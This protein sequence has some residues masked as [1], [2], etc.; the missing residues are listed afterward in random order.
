MSKQLNIS[1][2][3]DLCYTVISSSITLTSE[4]YGTIVCRPNTSEVINITLPTL[5]YNNIGWT[6]R[7]SNP[8]Q[9][10]G[11][12]SSGAIV[13][14][15][16]NYQLLTNTVITV[17]WD[18]NRFII[19]D[20][21]DLY[22]SLGNQSSGYNHIETI[23]ESTTYVPT[24]TGWYKVTCIGAGGGGGAGGGQLEGSGGLGGSIGGTTSFSNAL[25]ALGGGGGG[26]GAC[27]SGGAGGG[28]GSIT[29]DYIYLT[30]GQPVT[31]TIGQGGAGGNT[32]TGGS[33][34][35]G[36]GGGYNDALYG[37]GG[38]G[39]FRHGSGSPAGATS[40]DTYQEYSS[41]KVGGSGG[42]NSTGYGGGG[43]GGATINSIGGTAGEL[44][45]NGSNGTE[46]N[47]GNGGN[48]GNGAVILEYFKVGK[49]NRG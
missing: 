28:A 36:A 45:S 30:A 2:W 8:T 16:T 6:I 3:I 22:T 37:G 20:Y 4:S 23:T 46:S 24:Y 25:S 1:K 12:G 18:G 39:I 13:T 40:G 32:Q 44:G 38:Q 17:Y 15:N 49:T 35:G 5:S 7:I 43:G 42:S 27:S 48:G 29:Y 33:S 14:V 10:I 19:I 21:N 41:Y 47:P 26:G 31:I 9:L 11:S 34:D